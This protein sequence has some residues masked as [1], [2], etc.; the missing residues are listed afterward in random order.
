MTP[1]Q[2]EIEALAR[3]IAAE[4]PENPSPDDLAFAILAAGYGRTADTLERAARQAFSVSLS[5][6][7]GFRG[8]A[9]MAL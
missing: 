4:L 6:G 3:V 2:D 8:G 9:E 5:L 7:A 1:K